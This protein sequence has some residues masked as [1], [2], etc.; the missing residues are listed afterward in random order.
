VIETGVPVAINDVLNDKRCNR[1]LLKKAG[2]CAL[3]ALPLKTQGQVNGI[4]SIRYS[5]HAREFSQA[6]VDFADK[7]AALMSLVLENARL[8]KTERDRHAQVQYHANQLS[9]LH[10]IGLSLTRET[11]KRMLLKTVLQGAA[12]ITLAGIGAMILVEKGKTDVVSLYYA[13]WYDQRCTITDDA[14]GLHRRVES[15]IER[16]GKDT[17]RID[18]FGTLRDPLRFPDGH[19]QLRGLLIGTIRD[20]R[21]R[22][23]G[24]F[25][26]SQKGGGGS[27]TDEDEEVISLLSA[28]ASVAIISAENFE[29]EHLVAET[30]QSALLPAAPIRGDLEVGLIYRSAY[31]QSRLG[32]DFYDFIELE[33]GRLAIVIGDVCGKGLEAATATAMVKY[34]LRAYLGDGLEPGESLSRLNLSVGQQMTMDK[35]VTLGLLMIDPALGKISYASAGHPAPIHVHNGSASM[36]NSIQAIPLGVLPRYDFMASDIKTR[37]ESTIVLYTDGLTEARPRGG[38][39]FGEERIL[40]RAADLNR[41]PAQQMA[42]ELLEA[43]VDYSGGHLRDDIALLI[44][45]LRPGQVH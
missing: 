16:A 17:M 1:K 41:L 23:H 11:D 6:Q 40:E 43:A 5:N 21:G 15:L 13:P 12:E 22:A 38:E 9:L 45:K 19:P 14:S 28:Q 2:V 36:L 7:L 10:R 42:V 34:T 39:P 3:I 31:K 25:M 26:L 4:I 18:D 37:A 27:F 32:G 30:L 44:I 20:M 24:Y 29:R 33:D 35:F 8:Y